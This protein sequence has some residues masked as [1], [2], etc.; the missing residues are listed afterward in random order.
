MPQAESELDMKL[1]HLGCVGVCFPVRV[2]RLQSGACLL[3][4]HNFKDITS[5]GSQDGGSVMYHYSEP[6]TYPI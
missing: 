3:S 5:Q 6:D 1:Q 4:S 2:R